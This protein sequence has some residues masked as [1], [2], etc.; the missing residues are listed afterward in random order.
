MP[1]LRL[2]TW[3]TKQGVAPRQK[4]PALWDWI[5]R[6]TEADLLVLTEARVTK[7][8]IPEG[9]HLEYTPGGIGGRRNYGTIVAARGSVEIQRAEFP[10]TGP[11]SDYPHP[12]TTFAVEVFVNGQ[13]ELVL[14]GA[15]GLLNGSM[16]GLGEFAC[17]VS[18]YTDIVDEYG[19]DRLV[20]AGDF[21]LWPDHLLEFTEQMELV[22]VTGQRKRFPKLRDPVGGSRIWT[23]KNG[24]KDTDGA[25]Q[26]LDFIFVSEDLRD[27]LKDIRGGIDDFTD[28]WEMSDHAPVAVTLEF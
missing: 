25:R 15:Y 5:S 16:S 21:N 9:W 17:I 28:A 24:A 4:A 11:D 6:E 14:L 19:F 18:E 23:H 22:D 8:G 3:N 13:M 27:G 26:E 12:A 2:A 20:M 7:D 1:S 10:R